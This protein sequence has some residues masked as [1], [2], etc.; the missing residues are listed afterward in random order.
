MKHLFHFKSQ[1]V[2]QDL[3][4]FDELGYV[5]ASRA[6][7]AFL[8]DVIGAAYEHPSRIITTD[9]PFEN[10]TE[11]WGSKRLTGAARDR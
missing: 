5:P 10:G 7:G 2:R 3:V 6:G 8:F 1:L 11:V 4:L 9:S